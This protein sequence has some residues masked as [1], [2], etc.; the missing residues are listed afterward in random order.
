MSS[1]YQ[2]LWYQLNSAQRK[3]LI[4]Q[5]HE[6]KSNFPSLFQYWNLFNGRAHILE[7]LGEICMDLITRPAPDDHTFYQALQALLDK[8]PKARELRERGYRQVFNHYNWGFKA[9]DN[10]QH[11]DFTTLYSIYESGYTFSTM[12]GGEFFAKIIQEIDTFNAAHPEQAL[13]I[14][15]SLG[16]QLS[17]LGVAILTSKG[18]SGITGAGFITL[19][20]T[21]QVVPEIPVA[22]L[23]LILGVDRFMSEARAL[24]N[25]IGNGVATLVISKWENELDLTKLES[26]LNQTM[27]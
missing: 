4:W 18:A 21:L 5:N 7:P 19:A 13:N 14:D 16:Q 8:F 27:N 24:T 20:A 17:I 25:C 6:T 10:R 11:T 2:M 9:Q 26:E 3:K 23:A 22:G 12:L 1:A 15:L